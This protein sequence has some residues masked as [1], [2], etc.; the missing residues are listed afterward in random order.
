MRGI[1]SLHPSYFALVMATGIVSIACHFQG[2]TFIAKAMFWLNVVAFA[3]LAGLNTIRLARFHRS[4]LSDLADHNRGVGFFTSV[5]ASC[6]LGSQFLLIAGL[7]VIAIGF[8]YLGIG[9]WFVF[10]YT[11]FTSYAIKASK[12]SLAEGIHGGWL[13]SVVGAQ[14]VAML[15]GML[16]PDFG[17][18]SE[19]A[20]FF[21]LVMWLGGG[22]LYIWI[23][24]LIFYRYTFFKMSPTD[25]APAYWINMGAMAIS[26]L[27]GVTLIAAA[28]ES[29]ILNQVKP[30]LKGFTLFFWAT[31]T[32]WIPMLVI[33]GFW[34]HVV[35]RFG[36][37]YDPQYWGLVFPLG[38]YAA[39]TY[40]LAV[41]LETPYLAW[42]PI[43]FTYLSI[44]AWLVTF[45]GM[46]I[47]FARLRGV[48]PF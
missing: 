34:R 23:I 40:R 38:M 20:L 33:L 35:K 39:C 44:A 29:A 28:D 48:Q 11:I 45:A 47:S 10:T 41:T 3:V 37:T 31:A 26:T 32:W 22:M 9:L 16:A 4:F 17:T 21:S 7:P 14:G 24:S 8:W 36:F 42:I 25:L 43:T 46:M 13:I 2:F 15:G 19:P 12:P 5:A 18:Y 27:A 30:F 1:A 6:V